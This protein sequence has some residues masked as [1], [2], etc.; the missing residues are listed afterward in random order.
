MVPVVTFVTF[1]F[2][3]SLVF[4]FVIPALLLASSLCGADSLAYR[5]SRFTD[6]LRPVETCQT[7]V[8]LDLS[9]PRFQFDSAKGD[10]NDAV[11]GFI[12]RS[13]FRG[14]T[15]DSAAQVLE[16]MD[17]ECRGVLSAFPDHSASWILQRQVTIL[18][19]DS[20]ILSLRMNEF[21]FTGG[22]HP[23]TTDHLLSFNRVNGK[24]LSFED[25]F[26]DSLS[27]ALRSKGELLFRQLRSIPDTLSLEEAG[28]DF[29]SGRFELSRNFA[30]LD[31]GFLFHYNAY[32]IAPYYLG[33]TD[34]IIPWDVDSCLKLTG[35]H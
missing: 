27:E 1:R 3:R 32:D 21:R 29:G 5:I 24:V 7:S 12:L 25:L 26:S 6:S 19:N 31:S 9:F 11:S 15:L 35:K 18:R 13:L 34:L 16:E 10:W 22:A 30:L 17:V 28:F 4:M 20:D 33:A 8:K 23:S 2:R 14:D